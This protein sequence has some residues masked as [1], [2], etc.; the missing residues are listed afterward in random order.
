MTKL[1][2]DSTAIKSTSNNNLSGL[3]NQN[4]EDDSKGEKT[5]NW[6]Q[7]KL[8]PFFKNVINTI[9]IDFPGTL[10]HFF[11][12]PPAKAEPA[13]STLLQESMKDV[14]QSQEISEV[15]KE[16]TIQHEEISNM[17]DLTI[18]E[19]S[20]RYKSQ[21][22]DIL[23]PT[24]HLGEASEE[25]MGEE[26]DKF[27]RGSAIKTERIS[28]RRPVDDTGSGN[29]SEG[30]E[31]KPI[32]RSI[33]TRLKR[34]IGSIVPSKRFEECQF[35]DRNKS[36]IIVSP[37]TRR[38]VSS[39]QH[40]SILQI[41]WDELDGYRSDD[42]KLH[43]FYKDDQEIRAERRVSIK[44]SRNS[45]G[46]DGPDTSDTDFTN[47]DE[48]LPNSLSDLSTRRGVHDYITNAHTKHF[49]ESKTL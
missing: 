29:K 15:A 26:E 32:R 14:P 20:H 47:V 46:N 1:P 31:G 4:D 40:E 23:R 42:N 30:P 49:N 41:K 19:A 16:S 21:A 36:E 45:L 25:S 12:K 10:K 7:Q 17:D 37:G 2:F 8:K 24:L 9:T 39:I 13:T 48:D 44:H 5:I 38:S 11:K 27:E 28:V 6:S 35:D 33:E 22:M 34:R 43:S 3:N 18:F